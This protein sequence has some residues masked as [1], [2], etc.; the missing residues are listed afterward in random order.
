MTHQEIFSL[1]WPDAESY[2]NPG[3]F[4]NFTKFVSSYAVYTGTGNY[5]YLPSP[6]ALL[7]SFMSRSCGIKFE[8]HR[9]RPGIITYQSVLDA[10]Q[11]SPDSLTIIT[12][13]DLTQRTK[14]RVMEEFSSVNRAWDM[15]L[16]LDQQ[17]F[18]RTYHDIDNNSF[19]IITSGV[20]YNFFALL[21]TI[22][23][24]IF[25]LKF[26]TTDEKVLKFKELLSQLAACY[27]AHDI[28]SFANYIISFT[29]KY[30]M[31]DFQK[32]MMEKS[33]QDL[34]HL[35]LKDTRENIERVLKEHKEGYLSAL[36][37][38]Q[39][40]Q[41]LVKEY[42]DKLLLYDAGED[43]YQGKLH[44]FI[45]FLNGSSNLLAYRMDGSRHIFT[46]I[47][48]AWGS[49][50]TLKHLLKANSNNSI[51]NSKYA[52]VFE[53]IFIKEEAK[54]LLYGEI[55]LSKRNTMLSNSISCTAGLKEERMNIASADLGLPNPHIYFAG[56]LGNNQSE[57]VKALHREDYPYM[58][59]Q[60]V[61]TVG[62]INFADTGIMQ[63][64]FSGLTAPRHYNKKCI[65]FNN[66]EYSL[67]EYYNILKGVQHEVLQN[68]TAVEATTYQTVGT[69]TTGG[70]VNFRTETLTND[71]ITW[72][73]ATVHRTNT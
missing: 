38:L 30:I 49:K 26:N 24:A 7:Y 48:D 35:L 41:D 11:T 13:E 34:K 22:F 70:P 6:L 62:N 65:L 67:E 51:R 40:R 5:K 29:E 57:V 58:F 45:Q 39:K 16:T 20:N 47:A 71:P 55:Q 15:L 25:K 44:R 8:Q 33:F 46:I 19:V 54:L 1:A 59:L 31:K 63:S 56:C 27:F 23:P 52:N 2:G 17:H 42:E 61:N 66:E 37:Q 18:V 53:S 64:F 12:L 14:S 50:E 28:K 68:D 73:N 9:R 72:A 10:L 69:I 36:E 32:E 3:S 60:M 21:A 43:A 4:A